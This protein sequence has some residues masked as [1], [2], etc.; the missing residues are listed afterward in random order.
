[1]ELNETTR[2]N[3]DASIAS[4]PLAQTIV[5]MNRNLITEQ[6]ARHANPAPFFKISLKMKP[7]ESTTTLPSTANE[8]LT[9]LEQDVLDEYERLAENMKKVLSPLH[10]FHPL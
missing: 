6:R 2:R 4:Q 7:S 5:C 9:P 3:L 8:D 1:M 10:D